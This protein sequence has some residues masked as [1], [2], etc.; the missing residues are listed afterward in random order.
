MNLAIRV[1]WALFG[2][3]QLLLAVGSFSWSVLGAL[4]FWGAAVGT[5]AFFLRHSVVGAYVA[6]V[7]TAL[8]PLVVDLAGRHPF[9]PVYLAVN[10]LVAI[11]MAW[12][13]LVH[14]RRR[15]AEQY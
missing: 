8:G 5:L 12:L 15:A 1:A 9:G 13:A 6:A 4:V 10:L 14:E 11:L 3:Y 2:L 7:L